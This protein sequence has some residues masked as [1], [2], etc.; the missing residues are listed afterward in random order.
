MLE[1]HLTEQI[2]PL[3]FKTGGTDSVIFK[4]PAAEQARKVTID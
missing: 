3:T 1:A 4:G 2:Q